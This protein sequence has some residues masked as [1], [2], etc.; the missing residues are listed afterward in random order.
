MRSDGIPV[1]RILTTWKPAGLPVSGLPSF[2]RA[3]VVM[4]KAKATP[5]RRLAG[6]RLKVNQRNGRKETEERKHRV[7]R[8]QACERCFPV[9][10]TL[11]CK[12][13]AERRSALHETYLNFPHYPS[14]ISGTEPVTE[15]ALRD[16]SGAPRRRVHTLTQQDSLLRTWKGERDPPPGRCSINFIVLF[17]FFFFLWLPFSGRMMLSAFLNPTWLLFWK[18]MSFSQLKKNKKNDK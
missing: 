17:F 14:C 11:M 8:T 10:G 12:T 18:K 2:P 13:P 16:A 15:S 5:L 9:G 4:Q 1:R 3:P 7:Y 6:Q